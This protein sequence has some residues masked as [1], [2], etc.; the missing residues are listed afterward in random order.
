MLG[1]QGFAAT[2]GC[3]RIAAGK[4]CRQVALEAG[5][6]LVLLALHAGVVDEQVVA[7][8]RVEAG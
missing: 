8:Y 2:N 1:T 7:R 3:N 6:R 5:A 4:A